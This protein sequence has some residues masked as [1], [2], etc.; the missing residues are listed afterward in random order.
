MYIISQRDG[1][2]VASLPLCP[3]DALDANS[4]TKRHIVLPSFMEI[5]TT[6]LDSSTLYTSYHIMAT[7]LGPEIATGAQQDASCCLNKFPTYKQQQQQ[8]QKLTWTSFPS[9]DNR[10]RHSRSLPMAPMTPKKLFF[11]VF[12]KQYWSYWT[13][14]RGRTRSSA[15]V[16][17]CRGVTSSKPCGQSAK[18][19]LNVQF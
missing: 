4:H 1:G 9:Q 10:S 18:S 12:N 19:A 3:L 17:I 5:W 11:M 6:P 13:S 2:P 16:S 15:L 14:N 8:Q 7:S